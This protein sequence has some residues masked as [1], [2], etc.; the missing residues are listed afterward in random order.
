[1]PPAEPRPLEYFKSDALVEELLCRNDA[2]IIALYKNDT[3]VDKSFSYRLKGGVFE[4]TGLA[5]HVPGWVDQAFNGEP[6][7]DVDEEYEDLD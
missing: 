1:M 4:L 2:V 5:A 3:Q 7:A 6:G